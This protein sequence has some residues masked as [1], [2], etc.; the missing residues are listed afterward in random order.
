MV[1]LFCRR[2]NGATLQ[3]LRWALYKV[4]ECET[5]I[6]SNENSIW[7]MPVLIM[8]LFPVCPACAPPLHPHSK[9]TGRIWSACPPV[10]V[11][12]DKVY[13]NI[14]AS[15]SWCVCA[16]SVWAIKCT[17]THTH[18]YVAGQVVVVAQWLHQSY[19]P[20]VPLL[21]PSLSLCLSLCL[22]LSLSLTLVQS[23][24]LLGALECALLH[25]LKH[26][27]WTRPQNSNNFNDLHD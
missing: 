10:I 27:P 26:A 15:A 2:G 13:Y 21:S 12:A 4:Y 16:K 3:R 19:S 1:F 22:S 17:Y 8:P 18:S 25:T 24:L 5:R 20:A 7:I 11:W 14:C 6:A 9:H 23:V